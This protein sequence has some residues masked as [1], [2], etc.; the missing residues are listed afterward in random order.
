MKHRQRSQKSII[1]F[2]NKK[3][4]ERISVCKINKKNTLLSKNTN[5]IARTSISHHCQQHE[6]NGSRDK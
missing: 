1:Y 4:N 5:Q 6:Q 3:S 2:V